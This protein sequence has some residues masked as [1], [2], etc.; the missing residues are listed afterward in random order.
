MNKETFNVKVGDKELVLAIVRPTQPQYR[1]AQMYYNKVFA[2]L[3]DANTLMRAKLNEY[4][5]RQGIW[6]D[7]KEK[8]YVQLFD[9]I[10]SNELKLKK[11]GFKLSDAKNV[12][13]EVRELRTKVRDL[14]A[15]RSATDSNTAEAQA[16]NARFNYLV[17]QCL[18]YEDTGKPYYRDVEDYLERMDEEAAF[19]GAKRLSSI[20]YEIDPNFE[21]GLP[22]NKFLK[23]YGFIDDKLRLVN[24]NGHLVD[25]EGRL[26]NELGQYVDKN[27]NLVDRDGNPINSDGEYIVEEA[28]PFLDD[29]GKPIPIPT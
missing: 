27:G 3:L 17:A 18:V 13:L 1:A 20:L 22:E 15:Q 23:Q 2:E 21:A 24:K 9:R 29:D 14:V 4:M 25:T 12:A 11:G 26:I 6:S 8:Q 16:E 19:E 7:D 10:N 28:K 5:R